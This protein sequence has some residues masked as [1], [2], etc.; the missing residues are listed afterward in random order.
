MKN[1]KT[2]NQFVNEKDGYDPEF[3]ADHLRAE[4]DK[5]HDDMQADVE[6]SVEKKPRSKQLA[7]EVDDHVFHL[8]RQNLGIGQVKKISDDKKRAT[9]HFVNG[10]A[11]S[12]IDADKNQVQHDEHEMDMEHLKAVAATEN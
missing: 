9:V 6:S 10:L 4:I 5:D 12:L 8:H 2:Y 3:N 7:I 1:I 11:S